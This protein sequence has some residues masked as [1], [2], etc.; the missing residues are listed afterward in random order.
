VNSVLTCKSCGNKYHQYFQGVT[1]DAMKKINSEEAAW[2][3]HS[4][5]EETLYGK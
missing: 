2:A 5:I 1:F 4:Q 3:M